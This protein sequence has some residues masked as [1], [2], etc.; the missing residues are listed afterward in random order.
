[1]E[2]SLRKV[3]TWAS[4]GTLR[5]FYTELTAR[6]PEDEY[7]VDLGEEKLTC[8]RVSKEGGFLGIG[9]KKIRK[10]VLVVAKE[11]DLLNVDQDAA[12]PDFVEYLAT[13]LTQH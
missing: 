8:Y 9:A 2:D 10:P 1:M 13:R 4:H 6:I 5:Q 7:E 3:T 11:G 12:D